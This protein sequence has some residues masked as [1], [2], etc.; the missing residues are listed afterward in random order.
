MRQQHITHALCD[1]FYLVTPNTTGQ[2]DIYLQ[3]LTLAVKKISAAQPWFVPY[4]KL[5]MLRTG[6]VC[7]LWETRLLESVQ[8][9]RRVLFRET[10]LEGCVQVT[11]IIET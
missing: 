3:E 5:D 7:T 10:R 2:P 4:G 8:E 1:R 11:Q 9:T 6:K